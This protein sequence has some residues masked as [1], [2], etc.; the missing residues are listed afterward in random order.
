M[1]ASSKM[2][3]PTPMNDT[4]TTGHQEPTLEQ[5]VG[6]A[7]FKI[8]GIPNVWKLC[9]GDYF[10]D[11]EQL[12]RHCPF[13]LELVIIAPRTRPSH[14]VALE[15]IERHAS[16]CNNGWFSA[17]SRVALDIFHAV[18]P[19]DLDAQF[20][21]LPAAPL[22]AQGVA[23]STHDQTATVSD[24]PDADSTAGLSESIGTSF[25]V[26]PELWE[27]VESCTTRDAT[28]AIDIRTALIA[29]LGKARATEL[30]SR[31]KATVAKD[32]QGRN[33]RVLRA[34]GTLL[35]LKA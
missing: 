5:P 16:P 18:L 4:M 31:A 21:G 19:A 14:A 23:S 1:A 12:R 25:A 30:L 28:K 27:H 7:L 32:S 10:G 22:G 24:V 9:V 15:A 33:N 17:T 20:P 34:H 6:A 29:K 3:M 2:P 26:D 8:R 35:K 11:V 13:D